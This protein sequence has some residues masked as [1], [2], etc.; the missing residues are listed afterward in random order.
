MIESDFKNYLINSKQILNSFYENTSNNIK[1][2]EEDI[3]VKII[4]PLLYLLGY[5]ESL[6][7]REVREGL[8]LM[9]SDIE[10]GVPNNIFYTK[11]KKIVIE[12]KNLNIKL[13]AKESKKL[14][15]D[16]MVD[17]TPE[18]GI[19]TNGNE[20]KLYGK[21]FNSYDENIE[22][23]KVI[24]DI[25]TIDTDN[26]EVI[27]K[28][29]SEIEILSRDILI[30]SIYG[31]ALK[32]FS[33]F[34]KN[35]KENFSGKNLEQSL[36]GYKDEV[37]NFIVFMMEKYP[38][39]DFDQIN[40][41]YIREFAEYRCKLKKRKGYIQKAN[42]LEVILHLLSSFLTFCYD[43]KMIRYLP[44]ID[45]VYIKDLAN[46]IFKNT[47]GNGNNSRKHSVPFKKIEM[48]MLLN[49]MYKDIYTTYDKTNEDIEEEYIKYRDYMVFIIGL[50][51]GCKKN[52]LR[53]ISWDNINL[54]EKKIYISE[55]EM[56]INYDMVNLFQKYKIVYER[57]YGIANPVCDKKFLFL[58]SIKYYKKK[59]IQEIKAT[60]LSYIIEKTSRNYGID[61]KRIKLLTVESLAVT[62]I[63]MAFERGDIIFISNISNRDIKIK[64]LKKLYLDYLDNSETD[65]LYNYANNNQLNK[66]IHVI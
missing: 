57:Y 2:T 47:W 41:Y 53:T 52:D 33:D 50:Y 8:S 5:E 26:D 51:T 17:K 29:F 28:L 18:W 45:D 27:S 23:Y 4:N 31:K 46:N 6:I 55:L 7:R 56:Y 60:D 10:I 35:K 20:Y 12:A 19:L 48:Q 58:K 36:R 30:N 61:E 49:N 54:Q 40:G 43:T 13:G 3:K 1:I 37:K 63:A 9:K 38:K 14:I 25:R 21:P 34:L 65:Y 62:A 42:R 16:Y 44:K 39:V 59:G 22:I 32:A 24:L 11:N 66:Y 15:K 64:D